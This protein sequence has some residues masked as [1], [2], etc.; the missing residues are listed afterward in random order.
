MRAGF[1]ANQSGSP[2]RSSSAVVI[3]GEQTGQ[4]HCPI[5]ATDLLAQ[6]VRPQQVA[7]LP[8]APTTRKAMLR[9]VELGLQL[10]QHARA[11]KIDIGR[12]RQIA[13]D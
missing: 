6:A 2:S 1:N 11:G 4:R 7:H 9:A 8:R 12:R 13:D 10:V 3:P 5:E